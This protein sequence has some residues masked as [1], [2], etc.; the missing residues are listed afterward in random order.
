MDENINFRMLFFT[1]VMTAIVGALLGLVV[2]HIAE[3][4]SR[5][6]TAIIVGSTLGF[7]IGVGYEAMQQNREQE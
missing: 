7:A 4:E 2:A 3:R 6:K 5:Q 1:G